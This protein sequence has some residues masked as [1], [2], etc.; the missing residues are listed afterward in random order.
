MLACNQL[1]LVSCHLMWVFEMVVLSWRTGDKSVGQVG[2]MTGLLVLFGLLV[3]GGVLVCQW[4]HSWMVCYWMS[5]LCDRPHHP[6]HAYKA[7][8]VSG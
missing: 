6:I 5:G 4:W 3:V 1:I 2:S 7:E 8:G